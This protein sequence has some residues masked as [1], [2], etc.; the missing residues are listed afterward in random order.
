MIVK[1]DHAKRS[2]K[3]VP[4]GN[5]IQVLYFIHDLVDFFLKVST[6][7]KVVLVTYCENIIWQSNRYIK[8]FSLIYK[9]ILTLHLTQFIAL[10]DLPLGFTSEQVVEAHHACYDA[11]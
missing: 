3:A 10:L 4:L 11:L 5:F 6:F 9:N 2:A 1:V 8:T 7:F